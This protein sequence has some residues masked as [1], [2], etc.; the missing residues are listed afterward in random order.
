MARVG[1]FSRARAAVAAVALVVV[2]TVLVVPIVLAG[3]A[4]SIGPNIPANNA[5][6]TVGD[7]N[8]AS[9]LSIT[10]N[11][12]GTQST[13]TVG[14]TTATLTVAS[15]VF[16]VSATGTGD[17]TTPACSGSTWNV[18][19]GPAIF[20]FT[21]T[22]AINLTSTGADAVHA[23]C[24]I[25]FTVN[26]LSR[27]A[28]E[29]TTYSST[30]AGI[31]SGDNVTPASGSGAGTATINPAS[32]TI[33]TTTSPSAGGTGATLKDS[34]TLTG[35][36]NLTGAGT[37]TFYLFAPGVTCATNGTGAVYS[38]V[39][40][41][42]NAAGPW[43]T[44][45][46]KI[47]PQV[48]GTYQWVAVFSGDA[49]NSGAHSACGDEPVVIT[50]SP[51]IATT[52]SPSAG[53]T[54]AT[55]KD[56]A[57]LT[58][59]SNLTGAGTITFY[60]FAPGVT[61]AT[62]GTGAVYSEVVSGINAAGPW[63][64]ATGK[65]PPQVAGTYQWVA[66][67]SGDANNSGAHSACGDEPVVITASPTIATTTSP[68]AGGTGATL[69]DSATLT[70]ASNLTGAG[71]ITFY[72]FAPGVT[73]A[74][75][76]TGAVYSEVVSGINAAGPW[77]TATG[78]IPPQV[79]GTY[80]WVAVFSGDANNSGAHSA[81]GDEPVVITASPTIA[82]TT[83]P[84]AG[85][86]GA[87]L[88]DS[89][90]LTGASNLTGAGTITFYLF[91]PGVT[92][93]TNGTGAVYSEVV[94]GINAAGPWTTATGKIPPQVAGTYQW[95]AVFSGDA[96]NSGAHSACGD[97]PV[98][99][100]DPLV[101]VT[102]TANP[103]GPVTAGNAIGFTVTVANIGTVTAHGVTLN[104]P[105]PTTP[106]G[107]GTWSISSGPTASGTVT[108][109]PTCG[110]SSNTLTCTTADL[111]VGASYTLHVSAQTATTTNGTATNT[112]TITSTDGNCVTGNNDSRCSSTAH[113]T[114]TPPAFT[115]NLTP[116]YWKNH[117]A[118]TTALLSQTLGGYSVTTFDDAK[119]I[120]SGMGCG[121]DGAL[122]CMA[123]MLLAA[124]LNLQQGGS[125]CILPVVAQADA[126]SWRIR[127][128]ASCPTRCPRAT[129]HWP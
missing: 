70:G 77:T 99:I 64:T 55:L 73:C 101:K 11:S 54:G 44:A 43:T 2:T 81:C 124:K 22:S 115:A 94:S 68:S 35:A 7:T 16:S 76:G 45:T 97:E 91:A 4:L 118:A 71:T 37:I 125:T 57:T 42:I 119:I 47:P 121:H 129:R 90:T 82:T 32:P 38:E 62:N 24:Q 8:V 106:A 26:V 18:T 58:G 96:N 23:V 103:A 5:A 65:I 83:S 29:P 28:T 33:A 111:A 123:G 14:I 50:A 13:G 6:V 46:G 120:L 78:K 19:G 114:I 25:D 112:A 53:G 10:N 72:L 39:V 20:T 127:T 21:P 52:T 40:S 79:A 102:K 126:C 95:V 104:D 109:L 84:S 69:K 128:T 89:A 122:N 116:G 27:P 61:C 66:V 117:K 87:T 48:A 63:T 36:S 12:N 67:F 31:W 100:A 113:V 30:V 75:N 92:C 80:Q 86:T 1:P 41:G 9:T 88:K 85:G 17:V 98:V 15:G 74:T 60:L 49:N 110:V 107:I 51:T 59:A 108:P 56:S 3:T 105:L 93:A 34:A